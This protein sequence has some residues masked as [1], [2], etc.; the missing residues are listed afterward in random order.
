[1]IGYALALAVADA[2]PG[3]LRP[4]IQRIVGGADA[5][6]PW[7]EPNV[8]VALDEPDE[9]SRAY[10]TRALGAVPTVDMWLAVDDRAEYEEF[11]DAERRALALAVQIAVECDATAC[12]TFETGGVMMRR[13][14]GV[15]VLYSSWPQWSD[16]EL[17]ARL[18]V[19]FVTT[20]A[21]EA[22]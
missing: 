11:V 5:S 10:L 14:S 8:I 16:P 6:G 9:D 22:L 4:K 20:E 13:R 1:M 21:N 12:L 18:G 2:G 17:I 15:V 7:Q 3:E 19:S